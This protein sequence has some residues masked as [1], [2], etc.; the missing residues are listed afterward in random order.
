MFVSIVSAHGKWNPPDRDKLVAGNVQFL[1][2]M[3]G[4][5]KG[6]PLIRQAERHGLR[7]HSKDGLRHSGS[8]RANAHAGRKAEALNAVPF[9]KG[10]LRRAAKTEIGAVHLQ[11]VFVGVRRLRPAC[12]AN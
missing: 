12:G 8:V 7:R 1:V 6:L 3:N 9:R 4:G 11:G 2:G 10:F 5:G